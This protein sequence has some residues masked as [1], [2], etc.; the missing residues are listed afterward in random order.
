MANAD[1]PLLLRHTSK[2]IPLMR[3]YVIRKLH[4]GHQAHLL[5]SGTIV[6]TRFKFARHPPIASIR[7]MPGNRKFAIPLPIVSI[8]S[9]LAPTGVVNVHMFVLLTVLCSPWGYMP[10]GVRPCW[11]VPVHTLPWTSQ[12]FSTRDHQQCP[13]KW[14][15]ASA[16]HVIYIYILYLIPIDYVFFLWQIQTQTVCTTFTSRQS[17][18][19]AV[20]LTHSRW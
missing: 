19:V 8:R 11:V 20:W 12:S 14:S 4:Y 6:Q 3:I 7:S 17:H 2:W 9:L 5:S 16:I 13:K 10:H 1:F 15:I 18:R